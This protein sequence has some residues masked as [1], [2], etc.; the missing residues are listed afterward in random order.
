MQFNL[1]DFVE[2]GGLQ[3]APQYVVGL[4]GLIFNDDDGTARKST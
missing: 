1:S 2:T 4:R 3:K